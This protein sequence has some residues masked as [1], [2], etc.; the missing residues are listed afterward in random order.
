[1]NLEKGDYIKIN[2]LEIRIEDIIKYFSFKDMLLAEGIRNVIPDAIDLEHAV[3]VYYKFY[4]KEDEK[5]YGVLA[6]SITV[7]NK[8]N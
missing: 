8:Q 3:N 4:D 2:D 5:I 1:M 7:I 6:I